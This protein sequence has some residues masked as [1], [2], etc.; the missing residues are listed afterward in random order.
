[1]SG[2]EPTQEESGY[3]QPN[4]DILTRRHKRLAKLV[5]DNNVKYKREMKT[6]HIVAVFFQLSFCSHDRAISYLTLRYW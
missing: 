1:M 2:D 3:G 5:K 4:F 6:V